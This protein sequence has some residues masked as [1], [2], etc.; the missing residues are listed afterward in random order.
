MTDPDIDADCVSSDPA[1]QAA[2]EE[3]ARAALAGESRR[4]CPYEDKST[5]RG[6]VTFS[7]SLRKYWFQGYDDYAGDRG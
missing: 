1:F 7:R 2:Y 4:S 3:G 5:G 6:S